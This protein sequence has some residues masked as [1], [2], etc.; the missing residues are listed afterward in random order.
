MLMIIMFELFNTLFPHLF[1]LRIAGNLAQSALTSASNSK[2]LLWRSDKGRCKRHL[3]LNNKS[4]PFWS[5]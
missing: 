5:R 1:T 4:F 3:P 2:L